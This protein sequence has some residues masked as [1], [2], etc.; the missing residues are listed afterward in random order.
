MIYLLRFEPE[1]GRAC[2]E[3]L[4][5]LDELGLS[6]KCTTVEEPTEDDED[7]DEEDDEDE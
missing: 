2:E 6:D 5:R 7:W 1:V 3:V 4:D